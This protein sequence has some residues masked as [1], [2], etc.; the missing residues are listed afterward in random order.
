MFNPQ[1]PRS[2]LFWRSGGLGRTTLCSI[3]LPLAWIRTGQKIGDR[4]DLSS[5]IPAPKLFKASGKLDGIPIG[6]QT[7]PG[8]DL[9]TWG[10]KLMVEVGFSCCCCTFQFETMSTH[11]NSPDHMP[12]QPLHNRSLAA[13]VIVSEAL[14]DSGGIAPLA[15]KWWVLCSYTCRNDADVVQATL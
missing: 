4:D 14:A 15:K 2:K 10:L 6:M 12:I 7:V 11:T 13:Q 8:C 5:Q 9:V 3:K 1:I